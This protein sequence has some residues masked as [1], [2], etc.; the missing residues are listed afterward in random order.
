MIIALLILT[1]CKS[2]NNF[3]QID[4]RIITKDLDN[5]WLAYDALENSLDSVATIQRLYIAKATPEFQKFLELRNF[6]AKQYVDW[7]KH[8]PKFWK[9][10][11]P[12][13]LTVKGRRPNIDSVYQKYAKYVSRLYSSRY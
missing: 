6:T 8:K 5:F 11:R 13:T 9:T 12:L 10:V 2:Q 4:Y 7:I 1:S 3:Q